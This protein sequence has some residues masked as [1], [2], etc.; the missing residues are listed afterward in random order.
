LAQNQNNTWFLGT[1]LGMSFTGG[2]MNP[3]PDKASPMYSGLG[4]SV[5]S[6]KTT[7]AMLLFTDGRQIWDRN[8]QLMPNGVLYQG[9]GSDQSSNIIIFETAPKKYFVFYCDQTENISYALVDLGLNN[10]NGDVVYK[11]K[12]LASQ[13]DLQFTAVKMPNS[14]GYWLITHKKGTNEFNSFAVINEQVSTTPVVSY[15][16]ATTFL[17]TQFSYGKMITE[18]TGNRLAYL[19]FDSDIN[20]SSGCILQEFTIDKRCGT[21]A[22]NK[23]VNLGS[24]QIYDKL[25]SISYDPTGK[26]LYFSSYRSDDKFSLAQFDMKSN[27]S[28]NGRILISNQYENI[29]DIQLGPNGKIYAS[30]SESRTFTSKISVINSPSNAG[31]NCNFLVNA[32]E[33]SKNPFLGSIGVDRFPTFITDIFETAPNTKKPE[34]KLT[35]NCA[36]SE[37]SFDIKNPLDLI[38]DSLEWDFGDGVTAKTISAKHIYNSAGKYLV[39]FSWFVCNNKFQITDTIKIIEKLNFNLG[40]DTTL[41]MGDTVTLKGPLTA[42]K[43]LWN[44]GDTNSIIW[45]NKPGI[46]SLKIQSGI[47]TAQDEIVI[48]YH[49]QIFTALGDEYFICDKEKELVKLDAGKNFISYRWTPTGDTTQWI[50]VGEVGDYF[51]IVKDFR[52]CGANDNTKVK[53]VCDFSVYFP[54]AFTPNNDGLNDYFSP[55]GKDIVDFNMRI[56]NRWGQEIFKTNN[57]NQ[58]WDGSYNNLPCQADTYY[59][60]SKYQGYKNKKL[61]EFENKGTFTLLR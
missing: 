50:I 19:F 31:N 30:S 61:L 6:D 36:N 55:I 49:P 10:G 41:C 5:M 56:Y 47:C 28:D 34:L 27:A 16:G 37:S 38:Y 43:Y 25:G 52:G 48:N 4:A 39:R 15:A 3:I 51:V 57:L 33:L 58:T 53:R 45:V 21:I 8:K 1:Y 7:G 13:M 12:L 23:N 59:Y 20:A 17:N 40:N 42:D 44:T 14:G 11:K 26:Y 35:A 18:A 2:I 60:T 24:N 9:T 29:G 54:N 32:I 22:L 46:Y